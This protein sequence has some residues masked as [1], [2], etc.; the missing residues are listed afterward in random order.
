MAQLA[1]Q[2]SGQPGPRH[3]KETQ[4]SRP[5]DHGHIQSR[6]QIS[7]QV[8]GDEEGQVGRLDYRYFH[9]FGNLH[10]YMMFRKYTQ[11]IL[12]V[13]KTNENIWD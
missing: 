3:V 7:R 9:W 1:G 4:Q 6:A 2:G 11:G 13:S 5:R 10:C 8:H 12:L